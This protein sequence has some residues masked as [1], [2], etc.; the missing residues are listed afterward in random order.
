[1]NKKLHSGGCIFSW[2]GCPPSAACLLGAPALGAGSPGWHL[3]NTFSLILGSLC[4]HT[5]PPTRSCPSCASPQ[6]EA[7]LHPRLLSPKSAQSR[8]SGDTCCMRGTGRPVLK[9]AWNVMQ[10]WAPSVGTGVC[11]SGTRA[12]G[13]FDVGRRD[14]VCVWSPRAGW[15]WGMTG[16]TEAHRRLPSPPGYGGANLAQNAIL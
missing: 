13:A 14:Q 15:E 5:T 3:L 8:C 10:A 1:M 4:T 6:T 2:P 7:S 9:P 12:T 11:N 16:E